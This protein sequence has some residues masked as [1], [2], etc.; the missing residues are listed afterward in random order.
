MIAPP[1]NKTSHDNARGVYD[2]LDKFEGRNDEDNF[3]GVV[4]VFKAVL[5]VIDRKFRSLSE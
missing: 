5:T 1:E 3:S 2:V 4:K